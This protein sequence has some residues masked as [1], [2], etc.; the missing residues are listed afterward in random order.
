MNDMEWLFLYFLIGLIVGS[1]FASVVCRKEIENG[2][3][4]IVALII[5]ISGILWPLT[6]SFS[7]CYGASQLLKKFVRKS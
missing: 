1:A 3:N 5:M 6:L 7:I 4:T 2:D